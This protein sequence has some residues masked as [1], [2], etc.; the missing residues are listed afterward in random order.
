MLQ[1][2]PFQGLQ[3]AD[4]RLRQR[5]EQA[6]SHSPSREGPTRRGRRQSKKKVDEL[7]AI[8]SG[9]NKRLM[10]ERQEDLK[11]EIKERQVEDLA[12]EGKNTL[13]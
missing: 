10:V 6:A 2:P 3:R 11:K 1:P 4:S 13:K 12:N 9:R 5:Q 7:E 8:R